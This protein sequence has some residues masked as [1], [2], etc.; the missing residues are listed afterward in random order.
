[1]TTGEPRQPEEDVVSFSNKKRLQEEP[2]QPAEEFA[3]SFNKEKRGNDQF[4]SQ[5]SQRTNLY[6]FQFGFE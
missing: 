3:S 1:M 5:G 6:Y 2:R 4:K